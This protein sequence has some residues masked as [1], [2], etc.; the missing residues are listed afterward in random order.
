[1]KSTTDMSEDECLFCLGCGMGLKAY[2]S[3]YRCLL[4]LIGD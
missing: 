1:M 3:F 2:S 4:R